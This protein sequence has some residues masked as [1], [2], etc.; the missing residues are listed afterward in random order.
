MFLN[1]PKRLLNL[2][3]EKATFEA[4]ATDIGH[5]YNFFQHPAPDENRVYAPVRGPLCRTTV[6][7]FSSQHFVERPIDFCTYSNIKE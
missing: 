5:S 1:E 7:S 6:K 2:S 3:C 4:K